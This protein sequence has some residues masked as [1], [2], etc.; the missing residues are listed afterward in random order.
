MDELDAELLDGKYFVHIGELKSVR[1][2]LTSTGEIKELNYNQ[3]ELT[4]YIEK[5]LKVL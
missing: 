3:S 5:E 4:K 2:N 1:I